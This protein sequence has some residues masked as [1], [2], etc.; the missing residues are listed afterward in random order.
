MLGSCLSGSRA[1]GAALRQEIVAVLKDSP[2][3]SFQASDGT[4][5]GLSVE[6]WN[7]VATALHLEARLEGM[8]RAELMDAVASGRARFG[9][10][11][12]SITAA[13]LARVDFSVPIYGT[14][15]A[16]A[17][18]YAHRRPAGVLV[19]AVLSPTFL[20]LFGGLLVVAVIVGGILWI[21]ER[22]ANPAFSRERIHGWG[23]GIWLSL[24]TMTTVGYGDTAPRTLL[25]RVVATILMFTGIVMISIFTGTV[26][27]LL[28][29]ERL[30]PRIASF[31]DLGHARV[32]AVTASAAA[33][34]MEAERLP[35]LLFPDVD[36][37]LQ[38]LL[39]GRADALVYDRALLASTLVKRPN[40]AVTILPGVARLEYYAFALRPHE[41]L[42]RRINDVIARTLDTVAWRHV[43]F[44][45][46]GVHGEHHWIGYTGQE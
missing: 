41:P 28:T 30:G 24:V 14:G 16:V 1:E 39:D 2:P 25:G 4:W 13:R 7:R 3:F 40:L 10:G 43:Q 44:T 46:L 32:A 21:A 5:M 20:R 34:M 36:Q 38:A 26:A 23:T 11:P 9:V 8:D 42:R 31:E 29:I 17:V 37:A 19:D 35:A 18:P 22:R 33:Q 27:T 45:Y 12:L 15:V 6:M